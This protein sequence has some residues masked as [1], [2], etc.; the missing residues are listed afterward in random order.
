MNGKNIIY[1]PF[2]IVM[3]NPDNSSVLPAIIGGIVFGGVTI[4]LLFLKPF[5]DM[6]KNMAIL[7]VLSF[8]IAMF[9]QWINYKQC[10]GG[11]LAIASLPSMGTTGLTFVAVSYIR[12][13]RI[14]IASLFASNESA[15]LEK[16]E[17]NPLVKATSYGFYSCFA[18]IFGILSG[19]FT[20][21]TC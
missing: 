9:V 16:T 7:V 11:T 20:C 3:S 14:P 13:L 4:I 18:M 17:E 10:S 1:F 5:E 15:T 12:F 2:I 21:T 8:G 19:A 6:W